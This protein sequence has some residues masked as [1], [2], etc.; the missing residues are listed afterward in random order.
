MDDIDI[1]NYAG[2]NTPYVTTDNINGVIAS[3]ENA[4]NT[5]FKWFSDNL[6]KGNAAKCYLIVNVNDEGSMKIGD[7][8]KVNSKCEKLLGVKFDYK[9]TF[10]SHVSD[11]CKNASQK[12]NALTRVAPYMNILKHILMNAY[13]KLEFNYCPLV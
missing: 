12:I 10:N 9:L 13:F 6:F 1:A 4:S 2:D 5:L 3:L 7:F 8:V 11:L